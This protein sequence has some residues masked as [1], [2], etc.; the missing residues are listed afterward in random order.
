MLVLVV[1]AGCGG[2]GGGEDDGA[3]MPTAS[4]SVTIAQTP[5]A[6]PTTL[7]TPSPVATTMAAV[8]WATGSQLLRSDDGGFTWAGSGLGLVHAVSFADRAVGWLVSGTVAGVVLRTGDGGV[9]W[10]AQG[11]HI[12]G[13]PPVLIDVAAADRTHV[14]A[15][16]QEARDLPVPPGPVVLFSEDG[17]ATWRRSLL[18][19][20]GTAVADVQ[21]RTVCIAPSG[22]GLATGTDFVGFEVSL[23]LVT[24][25]GGRS[26]EDATTRVPPGF[27]AAAACDLS[28]RLW[29]LGPRSTVRVSADGGETWEDRQGDLPG[30]LRVRRGAFLGGG[31]GW[32]A[33]SSG[34]SDGRLRVFRTRDDGVT[35]EPRLDVDGLGELTL[36]FDA[37]DDRSAVVVAQDARPLQLPRSSFGRSWATND[38][39]ATW[40]AA[41]HP[42]TIDALWDVDL[43]S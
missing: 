26:W 16:G 15:V 32:I 18:P 29:F 7:P 3:P 43:V 4:P 8:A 36:G 12:V 35:W 30:S 23:V 14:V 9:T 33:T 28:G 31:L 42:P 11:S 6:S 5:L 24:R 39:G 21:L 38:G 1:V 2:D 17:G 10:M 40:T 25:D 19:L 27:D 13:A 20:L 22:A 34:D 41:E 37:I